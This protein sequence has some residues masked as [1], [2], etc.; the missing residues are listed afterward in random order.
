MGTLLA[1]TI[2]R[3]GA[4]ATPVHEDVFADAFEV[5]R[6]LES[7]LSAHD[8]A[9]AL[10]EANRKAGRG[11]VVSHELA[12]ALRRARRL[13][14]L[15]EGAFDPTVGPLL[16]LWR[17]ATRTERL[18]LPSDVARACAAVDWRVIAVTRD[19]TALARH[20]V[21]LDL[22]AFGK[23]VALD[24]IAGALRR[25]R[26]SGV[27]NFGESS[28][29]VVGTSRVGGWRV[30]LRHPSGG[31]VGSFVLHDGACSTSA[32]YGAAGR[33]GARRIGHVVDPRTGWPVRAHAQVTVLAATAAVA[34]A[35]STALLVLGP[36]ALDRLAGRLG[37]EACWVEGRRLR[38]TR[39]F[40]LERAA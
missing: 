19:R 29:R 3:D 18:P 20:G 24:A 25:R 32:T 27:L 33:V 30:L 10:S 6:R 11:D 14:H 7:V 12:C 23:G 22:G 21:R 1:V 17:G 16:D 31:F 13:A 38:T 28:L 26:V 37:V 39:G 40:A 35:A 4:R 5:A 36:G 15:T 8:P 2:R 34:E 9:S